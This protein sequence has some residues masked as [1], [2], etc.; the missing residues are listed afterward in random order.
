MISKLKRTWAEA[1]V[2]AVVSAATS[3]GSRPGQAHERET[4]KPVFERELPNVPGKSLIAVVVSYA[5]GGKS[6]AHHHARSAFIFAHVLTG[7][8]RSRVGDEPAKVYRAGESFSEEP[9]AYH[10]VSENAS[11]S[12]PASLL[13]VFIVGSQDKPL[14]VPDPDAARP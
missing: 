2:I 4:V 1:A 6:P 7:A 11:E 10:R 5:P 12:E 8:V 14:T 9:G 13:A 3:L